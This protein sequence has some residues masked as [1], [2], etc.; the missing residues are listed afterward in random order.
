MQYDTPALL[1]AGIQSEAHVA[2]NRLW[3]RFKLGGAGDGRGLLF[4]PTIIPVTNVDD[5]ARRMVVRAGT[6]TSA[7]PTN[8]TIYTV[9][10]GERVQVLGMYLGRSTGDRVI[11][12]LGVI[13]GGSSGTSYEVAIA[14]TGGGAGY[15]YIPGYPLPLDQGWR[16]VA[17]MSGGTTNGSWGYNIWLWVEEAF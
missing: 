8:P 16:I 12:T 14:T 7:V 10:M 6:F 17:A 11:D 1:R 9:P 2:L 3:A 15:D 4:L 5:L 13:Q